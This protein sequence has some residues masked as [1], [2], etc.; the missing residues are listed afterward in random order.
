MTKG[1][2]RSNAIKKHNHHL[3]YATT[4]EWKSHPPPLT[5]IE[6]VEHPFPLHNE[7]LMLRFTISV[8]RRTPISTAVE[9]IPM[10]NAIHS[11]ISTTNLTHCLGLH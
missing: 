9:P 1:T 6:R 3:E 8:P 2:R 5:N 7:H 10:S 11:L 4:S